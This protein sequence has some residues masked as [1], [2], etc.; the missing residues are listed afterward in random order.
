METS[1]VAVFPVAKPDERRAWADSIASG[2]PGRCPP[3]DD[4]H[5]LEETLHGV[6]L[7]QEDDPY[8][9]EPTSARDI[10][11]WITTVSLAWSELRTYYRPDRLGNAGVSLL[12]G[13][14]L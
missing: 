8:V 9:G 1:A 13:W 4:A 5:N 10:C 7:E 11:A 14:H 12:G 2:R 6:L 3:P